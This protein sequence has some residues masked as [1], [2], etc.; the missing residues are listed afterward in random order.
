MS[1]GFDSGASEL[2]DDAGDVA[3]NASV[4]AMEVARKRRRF[5][6]T[7]LCVELCAEKIY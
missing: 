4:C 1:K 2:I 6:V 3:R 7:I 5:I